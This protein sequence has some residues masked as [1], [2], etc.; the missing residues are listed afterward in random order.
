[1]VQLTNPFICPPKYATNS[2]YRNSGTKASL[3]S[4]NKVYCTSTSSCKTRVWNEMT[5]SSSLASLPSWYVMMIIASS[6]VW[7]SRH[8]CTLFCQF[9]CQFCKFLANVLLSH[10]F[11]V[12]IREH[13]ILSPRGPRGATQYCS[14]IIWLAQGVSS[15][16][17]T[18]EK[19]KFCEAKALATMPRT[20]SIGLC[21]RGTT[22][23]KIVMIFLCKSPSWWWAI[24]EYVSSVDIFTE[25]MNLNLRVNL[26]TTQISKCFW[27]LRNSDKQQNLK[28][29]CLPSH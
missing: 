18:R 22:T 24:S 8:F 12:Q 4:R 23:R 11:L 16:T 1:M 21:A 27:R 14:W 10:C 7:G 28:F 3:S 5:S 13:P 29:Y 25:L 2:L 19:P 9:V 17:F 6:S 15:A 26:L 20:G